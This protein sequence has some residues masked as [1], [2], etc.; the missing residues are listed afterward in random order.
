MS[1]GV[2]VVFE[3][4]DGAGTTTQARLASEFVAEETDRESHRTAE[5]SEG[6]VGSQIRRALA[7]DLDLD[8]AA[9]ALLFAADRLDHLDREVEPRLAEGAVVCCDRYALSSFAYQRAEADLDPAWLRSI[10]DR[11]RAP[12]LTIF[13]DVP[14]EVCAERLAADERGGERFEDLSTLRAVEA[15][16]RETV[17]AERDAG[18][19]VR[20]VDGTATTEDVARTVTDHMREFL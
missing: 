13:L 11:A 15:A 7:G 8:P 10:N 9:L 14:P 6:P 19:D 16:Y 17:A 18:H 12:D 5:P 3:G 20:V 4:L 1:D 2:F